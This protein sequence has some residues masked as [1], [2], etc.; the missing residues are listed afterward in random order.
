MAGWSFQSLAGIAAFVGLAGCARGTEA[1]GD[2][3]GFE[4][5]APGITAATETLPSKEGDTEPTSPIQFYPPGAVA[6]FGYEATDLQHTRILIYGPRPTE[7]AKPI[8]VLE[9][10]SA[11]GSISQIAFDAKRRLY[12]LDYSGRV[13]VFASGAT[14]FASPV[15]VINPDGLYAVTADSYAEGLGIDGEGSVYITIDTGLEHPG[16]ESIQVYG[17]DAS[18]AAEP[19]RV[20]AGPHTGLR[21]PIKLGFDADDHLFV[22]DYLASSVFVFASDA[23][24]DAAPIRTAC[25][26]EG[27][28][29]MAVAADGTLYVS[30]E[31]VPEWSVRVYAPVSGGNTQQLAGVISGSNTG[32]DP[33]YAGPIAFGLDPWGGLVVISSSGGLRFGDGALGNVAP[34]GTFAGWNALAVAP[35]GPNE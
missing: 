9:A 8:A 4:H 23:D 26:P 21:M 27:V 19:V 2:L 35:R 22:A 17:P 16:P 1:F 18:F 7:H 11:P 14:G 34:E 24:G 3:P 33:S 25:T 6:T 15:R 12:T 32:L 28:Y 20:I 5:A 13:N 29:A 31:G 10:P 30:P